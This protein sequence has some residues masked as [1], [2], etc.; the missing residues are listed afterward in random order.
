MCDC[1]WEVGILGWSWIFLYGS[2]PIFAAISVLDLGYLE[3]LVILITM[4][5]WREVHI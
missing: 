5:G 3:S 2:F 1:G 4:A